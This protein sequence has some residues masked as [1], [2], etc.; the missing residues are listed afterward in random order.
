MWKNSRQN[1]YHVGQSSPWNTKKTLSNQQCTHSTQ[2]FWGGVPGQATDKKLSMDRICTGK[3]F[4]FFCNW[5]ILGPSLCLNMQANTHA[6]CQS[7]S[8]QMKNHPQ[9]PNQHDKWNILTKAL[10]YSVHANSRV[11]TNK[12]RTKKQQIWVPELFSS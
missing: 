4:N 1:L 8:I 9:T 3:T 12:Q 11:R 2:G 10:I 7:H 6:Q 5:R